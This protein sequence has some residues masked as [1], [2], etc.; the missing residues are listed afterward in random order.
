M[1]DLITLM[2]DFGLQDSYVGVMKGVIYGFAPDAR[3]VDVTHLIQ[4][5]NVHAAAVLLSHSAYYFPEN[6]VHVFVVDPGVGTARRPIAARI[7]SQK[8]VGPDNGTLTLVLAR[9]QG[10][11]WP[12]EIVHLNQPQYWLSVI[13][14]SF[15]GRDIF[16]PVAARLATG[17]PLT[18]VGTP[19]TDP[20][21]LPIASVQRTAQGVRGEI[22]HIDH[23]GNLGTNLSHSDLADLG[24]VRIKVQGVE[25]DGLTK[26]FGDRPAGEVMAMIDSY[27]NLEVAV[28]NGNAQQRLGAQVGDAVE[29]R[30]V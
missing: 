11:G 10:E 23:F 15:H 24:A 29:I 7:G 27:G 21:R 19:I 9:A 14:N 18:A 1:T 16:S 2:T 30:C 28:V 22:I 20:V 17:T 4:P 6:T 25:V 5:Q 12:I 3:L 8:F 26:T 13:S